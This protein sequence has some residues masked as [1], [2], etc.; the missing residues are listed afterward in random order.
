MKL[1]STA[2]T[3]TFVH[4]RHRLE[5]GK[6]LTFHL[7]L[8]AHEADWRA[9]AR[10][11]VT[12]YPEYFEPEAQDV[13]DLVGLGAYSSE[14]GPL[15]AYKLHLMGF[16]TNWK[17]SFDF[18]YMGMFLPPLPPDEQWDSFN[19][20]RPSIAS[21]EAYSKAMRTQGF[22]VLNY[23]NVNEFGTGIKWPPPASETPP[24]ALWSDANAFLYGPLNEAWLRD[25]EGKPVFSWEWSVGMDP[26]EPAYQAFLLEQARRHLR[27]LPSSSGFCIDRLDWT[28]WYNKRGDDGASWV[29]G[30]PARSL[31]ASWHEVIGKLAP[32]VH[33]KGKAIFVNPLN[34]RVDLMNHVDGFYD[35][36]A[37]RPECLNSDA[38]LGL[39]K[40]SIAWVGNASV[41]GPKPEIGLQ[42]F[43]YM[44]V[45]PTAPV[46]GNDHTIRPDAETEPFYLTYGPLFRELRGR[47]WVLSPLVVEA[48]NGVLANVFEVPGGYVVPLVLGGEAKTAT[49]HLRRLDFPCP[50]EALRVDA[51][52]PG[53][54]AQPVQMKRNGAGLTLETPLGAGC[55]LIRL[56]W[57]WVDDAGP[58]F[59][60]SQA[61]TL[62]CAL[63]GADIRYT[64]DGSQPKPDSPVYTRPV[65]LKQTTDLRFAAFVAGKQVGR[66]LLRS[67]TRSEPPAPI[68]PVRECT[69]EDTLTV[70]LERPDYFAG[71]VLRY[72]LDGSE[73]TATSPE[74]SNPVTLTDTT[75]LRAR[76]FLDGEASQ[77]LLA[78]YS[79]W[80][81]VPPVADIFCSDLPWVSATTAW[82]GFV[83][84]DLSTQDQP[85]TLHGQV[86]EKGLGGSASSE[87]LY[88]LQPEWKRFVAT[89]GVDDEMNDW[90]LQSIQ[91]SVWVDGE[92][93]AESPILRRG[94]L[95]RFNVVLPEGGKRLRLFAWD[96]GD[97]INCDH[98]D[99]GGAGFLLS[100]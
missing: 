28:R 73:V 55:A 41:L 5:Q 96:T 62:H 49:V 81:P 67:Y 68:T 25:A 1:V 32:L 85:L 51:L 44:G 38:F 100:D 42:P 88:D 21:M 77:E 10:E 39:L 2:E 79:K 58:A 40:P 53:Q 8:I 20:R 72:T 37:D 43:L 17:A 24:D 22:R 82:G 83:R 70:E 87:I 95:W 29:E 59:T 69:F 91:F 74:W 3:V 9:G 7:R 45:Q 11:L 34:R 61:V 23:F 66:T 18:P 15:E 63:P 36:I 57:L 64:T 90:D 92:K 75:T 35:E 56:S 14:E 27:Y 71:G 6:P 13:D 98:A 19:H 94:D 89:V 76:L 4:E 86:F 30:V 93:L 65:V 50:L 26:G 12:R 97:S 78:T 31:I 16:R 84:R 47:H 54:T 60:R 48:E 46:P 80:P 99:W 33:A 52:L